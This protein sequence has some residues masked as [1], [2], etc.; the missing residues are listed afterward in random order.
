MRELYKLNMR[1][2]AKR[3]LYNNRLIS[4][5][6]GWILLSEYLEERNREPIVTPSPETTYTPITE[7]S[8]T[9]QPRLPVRWR[10]SPFAKLSKEVRRN[11]Y[12]HYYE[13]PGGYKVNPHTNQLSMPDGGPIDLSLRS[14]CRAFNEETKGLE[15]EWNTIHSATTELSSELSLMAACCDNDVRIALNLGQKVL[16]EARSLIHH[17]QAG[18]LHEFPAYWHVLE[19]LQRYGRHRHPTGTLMNNDMDPPTELR[20]L[21]S[22]LKMLWT[23]KDF[24]ATVGRELSNYRIIETLENRATKDLWQIDEGSNCR[25]DASTRYSFSAAAVMIRFLKASIV[26]PAFMHMRKL[27]MHEDRASAA[28]PEYHAKPFIGFCKI[29]PNLNV[30]RRVSLWNAIFASVHDADLYHPV[31]IFA[32]TTFRWME[33][34]RNMAYS[35]VHHHMPYRLEIDCD[36]M[37]DL[38]SDIIHSF[39]IEAAW[40]NKLGDSMRSESQGVHAMEET[41]SKYAWDRSGSFEFLMG[42][43]RVPPR[44]GMMVHYN[45]KPKS[46][47]LGWISRLRFMGESWDEASWREYNDERQRF[48]RRLTILWDQGFVG[49]KRNDPIMID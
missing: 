17:V 36:N 23:H 46:V 45:F 42:L 5:E 22:I 8:T 11:I 6:R 24:E 49:G 18:I 48:M 39:E 32:A 14:V 40:Q 15:F 43:L 13:I 33:E 10:D 3:E 34:A 29:N 4:T 27:H 19:D 37:P 47:R 41:H 1:D 16:L 25:F 31:N 9:P 7:R 35:S 26:N 21:S 44:E 30:H 2:P 38:A 20:F 12:R 28:F